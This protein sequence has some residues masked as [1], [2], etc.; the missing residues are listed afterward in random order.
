MIISARAAPAAAGFIALPGFLLALQCH[1]HPSLCCRPLLAR[2]SL[3]HFPSDLCPAG[4]K[5]SFTP[6]LW[7]P[8]FSFH[9]TA[10]GWALAYPS[11]DQGC[12]VKSSPARLCGDRSHH[13]AP[14]AECRGRVLLGILEP[15]APGWAGEAAL[16]SDK[17]GDLAQAGL[18]MVTASSGS[19]SRDRAG[20]QEVSAL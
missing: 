1:R 6:Q 3:Y 10:A 9:Y 16:S 15:T 2:V 7:I 13:P 19:G 11:P 14:A 17:C 4:C 18:G 5:L 8:P 12:P 20:L